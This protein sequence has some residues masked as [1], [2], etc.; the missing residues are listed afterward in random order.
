P[1]ASVGSHRHL[2]VFLAHVVLCGRTYL[3]N[4]IYF[5]DD[6]RHVLL[7][8]RRR[9]SKTQRRRG[10]SSKIGG[11]INEVSR[12]GWISRRPSPAPPAANRVRKKAS[13][14]RRGACGASG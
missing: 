13:G 12:C 11:S 7:T 1:A 5:G 2:F 8:P 3:A 14:N 6:F 9:F 4:G 10:Q